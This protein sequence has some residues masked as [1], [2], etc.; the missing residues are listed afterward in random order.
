MD[1]EATDRYMSCWVVTCEHN[2]TRF[3]L[4]HEG[5][6]TDILSHAM[7][8]RWEDKAQATADA[9]KVEQAWRGFAWGPMSVAEAVAKRKGD[10]N[11]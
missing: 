8:H 1:Y 6:S 3:Y 5:L 9:A 2:G 7:L 11:D 4:T 10:S